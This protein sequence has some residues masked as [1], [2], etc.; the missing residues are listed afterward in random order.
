MYDDFRTLLRG[1]WRSR[2]VW[3][4]TILLA[5]GGLELAG[6]HLSSLFGDAW[7][8]KLIAVGGVVNLY[9]RA[10]TTVSLREKGEQ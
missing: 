7:A 10:K 4:N 6:G 9:L 8:A 3:A 1:I 5:I 2:T